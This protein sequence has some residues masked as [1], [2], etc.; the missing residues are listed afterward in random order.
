MRSL[1]RSSIDSIVKVTFGHVFFLTP[2]KRDTML[3]MEVQRTSGFIPAK[4]VPRLYPTVNEKSQRQYTQKATNKR[5]AKSSCRVLHKHLSKYKFSD[6]KL[7]KN[8]F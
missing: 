1:C 2:M 7:F 4:T 8:L 5:S 6:R 3:A